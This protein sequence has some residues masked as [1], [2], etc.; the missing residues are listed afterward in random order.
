[1]P[2]T[3]V[4]DDILEGAENFRASLTTSDSAVILD[5]D[6]TQVSIIEDPNDGKILVTYYTMATGN[7]VAVCIPFDIILMFES[8]DNSFYTFY[9][10]F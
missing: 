9:N 6:T 5:T 10:N 7:T 4:N 1:M 2:V 8:A 3:I